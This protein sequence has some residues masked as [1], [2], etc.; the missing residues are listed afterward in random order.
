MRDPP[1]RHPLTR[2][3]GHTFRN[4]PPAVNKYSQGD[5]APIDAFIIGSMAQS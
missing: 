1:P 5:Q 2:Q 4:S 3:R